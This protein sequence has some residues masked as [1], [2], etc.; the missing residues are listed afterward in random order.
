MSDIHCKTYLGDGAY[1]QLG[2]YASEVVLTT[3]NGIS[4][5]NRVVLGATEIALLMHWLKQRG[6]F[7]MARSIPNVDPYEEPPPS[8]SK[9]EQ[10]AEETVR[11]EREAR[12]E[13]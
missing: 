4:V 6:L 3:E 7:D 13:T 11:E 10:E 5:Q 12:G 2:S 8:M 1:V 9:I